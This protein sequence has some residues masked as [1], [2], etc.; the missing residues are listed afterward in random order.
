MKIELPIIAVVVSFKPDILQ[1]EKTIKSLSSQFK[2]IVVVHNGPSFPIIPFYLN[3]KC[4]NLILLNKNIGLATA[5]NIGI[6]KAIAMGARTIYLSDQDSLL[7]N[8]FLKNMSFY[9]NKLNSK[10]KT[11]GFA[12][13]YFNNITKENSKLFKSNIYLNKTEVQKELG[14]TQVESFISSGSFLF[15]NALE[16]IGLMRDDLFID[17]IDIEWAFRAKKYGY[18]LFVFTSVILNHTLGESSFVIFRK[19]FPVHNPLRIY[20]YFRNA[21]ALYFFSHIPLT[22]KIMDFFKNILRLVFYLFFIKPRYTY[23]RMIF[24]GIFHGIIGRMGKFKV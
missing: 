9:A 17:Y 21:F 19:R 15:V 18:S 24:L 2:K 22:W 16:E 20:Y 12:P 8:S 5:F 6:N 4:I 14:I 7:P 23:L 10:T 3:S 1:F 13:R 11:A